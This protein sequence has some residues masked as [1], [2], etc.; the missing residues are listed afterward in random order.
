MTV[1]VSDVRSTIQPELADQDQEI[2][3]G[4]VMSHALAAQQMVEMVKVEN[5][6]PVLL[7]LEN[8]GHF[9]V[10]ARVVIV[11]DL[12]G[13]PTPV[14]EYLNAFSRATSRVTFL[15]LDQPSSDVEIA[16]LLRAGF[17]G[18]ITYD[19]S[20]Q[21]LGAAI[22]AVAQGKVWASPE[23]LRI[24]VDLTSPR[25]N[26]RATGIA[27]LTVRE[28]QILDL[29]RRRYSNKEIANHL[30]ISENTV[31]FH[32]SNVLTKLNVNDRRDV[33]DKEYLSS[34]T[35]LL[36]SMAYRHS[37]Y[38]HEDHRHAC[39]TVQSEKLDES[40]RTINPVKSRTG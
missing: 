31:K 25:N 37:S 36:S 32:V 3:V 38:G 15:A 7:S 6:R 2:Y 4:L 40:D 18:F 23:V 20:F 35:L 13:L 21:F 16:Q 12:W 28:N 8:T 9:P 33:K 29:L 17:A 30:G 19:Q 26:I 22:K 10:G 27:T 5:M 1:N 14:S 39:L 11:L 24:Y 34:T